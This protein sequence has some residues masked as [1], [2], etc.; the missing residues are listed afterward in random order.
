V[1]SELVLTA[2]RSRDALHARY[3]RRRRLGAHAAAKPTKNPLTKVI[4][5]PELPTL[6]VLWGGRMEPVGG[7]GHAEP[8]APHMKAEMVNAEAKHLATEQSVHLAAREAAKKA[9]EAMAKPKACHLAPDRDARA[10]PCRS[11]APT[12][13]GDHRHPGRIVG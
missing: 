12:R 8:N 10:S 4:A 13:V 11:L 5:H 9:T 3:D 7:V 1:A 2:A 6:T